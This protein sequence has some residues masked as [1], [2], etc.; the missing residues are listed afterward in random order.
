[1]LLLVT[2]EHTVWEENSTASTM[3]VQAGKNVLE[4][5]VVGAALRRDAVHVASIGIK[6]PRGAVPLLDRVGRIGKYDVEAA[7]VITIDKFGFGKRVTAFYLEV[8]D[9]VQEEVH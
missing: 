1:M 8:F 6:L 5:G 7:Q 2:K 4:E 3:W 9:A